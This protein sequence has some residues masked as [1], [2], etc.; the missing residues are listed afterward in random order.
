MEPH[1][2]KL[3]VREARRAVHPHIFA[4]ICL[5]NAFICS[6]YARG[7]RSDRGSNDHEGHDTDTR[8]ESGTNKRPCPESTAN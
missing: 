3:C 5:R 1:L 7:A 2:V 6:V 8:N 4:W